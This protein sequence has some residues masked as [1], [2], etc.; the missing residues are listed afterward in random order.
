MKTLS[1][2]VVAMAFSVLAGCS[3]YYEVKDPSTDK[4]YYTKKIQTN[5]DGSVSFTDAKSGANVTIQNS[6]TQ[7]VD[8]AAYKQAIATE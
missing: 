3:S 2:L 8:K 1:F 6:E 4:A 5:R 7:T